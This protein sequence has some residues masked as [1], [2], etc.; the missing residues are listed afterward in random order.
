MATIHDAVHVIGQ[1]EGVETAVV[2]G[3]DGLPIDSYSPNGLDA[4]GVSAWIPSLVDACGQLGQASTRG[5]FT[6]GVMEYGN[7]FVIV[8]V[9]TADALFAVFVRPGTDVGSLLYELHTYRNA[10]AGL[11]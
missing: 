11:L 7:G 4:D 5:E 10:I 2:L 9:I 6:A 3:R 1:R 8:A